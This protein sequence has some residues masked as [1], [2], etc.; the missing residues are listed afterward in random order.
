MNPDDEEQ[1]QSPPV[2]GRSAHF[3]DGLLSGG[4][5]SPGLAQMAQRYKAQT[6]TSYRP[7]GTSNGMSAG[8]FQATLGGL[9]AV[10]NGSASDTYSTKKYYGGMQ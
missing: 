4:E 1:V 7:S 3:A 10:Q 8:Q 9:F 2:S 6:P 5:V